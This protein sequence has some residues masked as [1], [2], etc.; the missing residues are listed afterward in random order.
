MS[1]ERLE[2]VKYAWHIDGDIS[3]YHFYWLIEQVTQLQ[4]E[5]ETLSSANQ[6]L[7]HE[8]RV[9]KNKINYEKQALI[10]QEQSSDREIERL[11]K[12]IKRYRE[13]IEKAKNA[14]CL[15][16]GGEGSATKVAHD[17]LRKA[18]EDD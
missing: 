7:L 8:V 9:L 6:D 16:V 14:M 2:T 4:D 10:N 12:Q 17:I 11:G 5:N 3:D 13:A 1:E 15:V 18:L